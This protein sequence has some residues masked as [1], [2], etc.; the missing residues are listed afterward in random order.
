MIELYIEDSLVELTDDIIINQTY[1]TLDPEKLSSIKNSFSKTVDIPGTANNNILFGDIFRVDRYVPARI[2]PDVYGRTFNK[3]YQYD[4]HKKANY[5]LMKNGSV[6]NRGYCTLDNIV[7]KSDTSVTYKLTLYGGIGEFFYSLAYDEYGSPKTLY[8]MHWAWRHRNFE[9]PSYYDDPMTTE[10]ENYDVIMDCTTRNV[11]MAYHLL[12]PLETIYYDGETYEHF[13]ESNWWYDENTAYHITDIDKDVVFVPC[14]TGTYEDFDSKKML[15]STFNQR[16]VSS[17][18]YVTDNTAQLLSQS[19]PD[20]IRDYGDDPNNPTLYYTMDKELNV[21]GQYRYGIATFS[22]DIDPWEAGDIRLNEMPIAIRL[23]KLMRTLSEPFNNGGYEV[24]WNQEILDSPYWNYS[25]VMLGKMKQEKEDLQSSQTVSIDTSSNSEEF[26]IEWTN[27]SSI[28]STVYS[29]APNLNYNSFLDEITSLNNLLMGKYNLKLTIKLHS[30]FDVRYVDN[31]FNEYYNNKNYKLLNGYYYHKPAVPP[32]GGPQGGGGGLPAVT[33]YRKNVYVVIYK[34]YSGNSVLSINAHF[35][36]FSE[37]NRF[38]LNSSDAETLKARLESYYNFT[39]DNYEIH[40]IFIGEVGHNENDTGY[41]N[42]NNIELNNRFETTIEQSFKVEQIKNIMF[43]D[44]YGGVQSAGIYGVDS[45]ISSNFS[46]LFWGLYDTSKS[47]VKGFWPP[48]AYDNIEDYTYNFE[49][50]DVASNGLYLEDRISGFRTLKLTK[51]MLF[52]ESKSP[53]KYLADLIKMMNWRVTADNMTKK[54]YIDPLKKFYNGRILDINDKVDY[55][56]DINIK[57]I[58]TTAKRINFGLETLDTYPISLYNRIN[59]DKFNLYHY[60][61]GI[62]YNTSETGLLDNLIYKSTL[63]WQ[64]NSIFYNIITSNTGDGYE[65][66]QFPKAYNTPTI[67]WTLFN[68]DEYDPNDEEGS[69]KRFEKIVP[70]C[71]SST[72]NLSASNDWLPKISLFNKE[73]KFVEPD[74]TLI[75]LNGFVANYDYYKVEEVTDSNSVTN[76]Y[77]SVF[78]RFSIS[79][80][81]YE[82]YYFCGGRCYIY[83]FKYDDQM[84]TWGLYSSVQKGTAFSCAM[85]FF[86]RELYNLYESEIQTENVKL[87]PTNVGDNQYFSYENN[88]YL[89]HADPNWEI[90]R[91]DIDLSTM[92]NLKFTAHYPAD[93][94]GQVLMKFTN[95]GGAIGA[96]GTFGPA[97]HDFVDSTINVSNDLSTIYMNVWKGNAETTFI[98][99]DVLTTLPP[100]WRYKNEIVASWNLVGQ[101]NILSMYNLDKT[102]FL[103]NPEFWFLKRAD[104]SKKQETDENEYTISLPTSMS[105]TIFDNNWK[106]YMNDLYDRNTRDVTLYI[107]LSSYG[108]PNEI[109]RTIFQWQGFYWIPM[110]IENFKTSDLGQDKF[111]KCTIHKIKD[112]STWLE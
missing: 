21:N 41:F 19:F 12:K 61:T 6:V 52:A 85:P 99:A 10:Q 58:T 67:S 53:L 76:S 73:N 8:D 101:D 20:V 86:T 35:F 70:G 22:R 48:A 50:Q 44:L 74:T 106:D 78:P 17:T 88:T 64:Q 28:N 91:Y 72:D 43:V 89:V 5:L 82:Q 95:Y 75:F 103:K 112:I 27:S 38:N 15:V 111:T 68:T 71:S 62:E 47:L 69:I 56:R 24:E 108:N 2:T 37:Y 100:E 11:N 102:R 83:D 77:Y 45:S 18:K 60:V 36:L 34:I 66:G 3:N 9:S 80:D 29:I 93:Q 84:A 7:I 90:R 42:S 13:G 107:D 92:S 1:E 54:I 33:N 59:K 30:T 49:I 104:S 65:S 46:H 109:M 39:I 87:Q 57:N 32:H 97:Q 98:T 25:W 110:K 105:N 81:T 55:N 16:W 26:D 31:G 51:H 4:P 96:E 40:N 94:T 14:Y 79:E 23:S 63:D